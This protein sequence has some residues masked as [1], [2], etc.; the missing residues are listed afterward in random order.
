ML[1][2]WAQ[3]GAPPDAGSVA[4]FGTTVV[5]STGFRGEVF[6]IRHW[7]KTLPKLENKKPIGEIYT[8]VLDVPPQSFD[9][10]F[11]GVT[12]RFEWFAIDYQTKF[13]IPSA[14]V[15]HF[16]LQ[17]DDAADLYIDG[18]LVIDND[19]Q[20][21]PVRKE[22]Q[23]L[24]RPGVHQMRVPYY[25]GPKYQVALVLQILGPGERQWR[26]FNTDE[27]MPPPGAYEGETVRNP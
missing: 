27:W 20:H 6:R 7:T 12:R 8:K 24:L 22:G 26:L 5:A 17:A 2:L 21:P 23:M 19:G 9:A 1:G 16:A 14:G 10:G 4:H 15:Y 13:W 3:E 18:Q 25:Q 11:P